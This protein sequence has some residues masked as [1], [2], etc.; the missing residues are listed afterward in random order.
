MTEEGADNLYVPYEV[1][2]DGSG[3]IEDREKWEETNAA[4]IRKQTEEEMLDKNNFKEVRLEEEIQKDPGKDGGNEITKRNN[5]KELKEKR[6]DGDTQ[7]E[8]DGQ[9]RGINEVM[10]IQESVFKEEEKEINETK[11]NE[12]EESLNKSIQLNSV[13]EQTAVTSDT[14]SLAVDNNPAENQEKSNETPAKNEKQ[15]V[16]QA[17][18]PPKVMSAATRFQSQAS[19]QTFQL[20]SI[21]KVSAES[22]FQCREKTQSH[23]LRE[24]DTN[25]NTD[26]PEEEHHPPLKVSELKKRFET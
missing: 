4:I 18:S 7:N 19:S 23:R 9:E 24:S 17:S 3:Q 10:E 26:T 5:N 11:T 8:E 15:A 14:Q 22:V 21:P 25:K 13:E 12:T 1:I 16:R 2:E 6:N 20:R